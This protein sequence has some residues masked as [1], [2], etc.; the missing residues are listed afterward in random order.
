MYPTYIQ[1]LIEELNAIP[2]DPTPDNFRRMSNVLENTLRQLERTE[3]TA[4][5][6]AHA[7]SC[8]LNGTRPA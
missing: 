4:G 7:A 2:C 8:L 1:T 6:A 5:D 3:K